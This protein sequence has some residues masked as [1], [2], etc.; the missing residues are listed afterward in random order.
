MRCQRCHGRPRGHLAAAAGPAGAG[1]ALAARH[2][3]LCQAPGAPPPGCIRLCA[4]LVRV[5]A[6]QLQLQ[7]PSGRLK[8]LP[9]C[10]ASCW[11]AAAAGELTACTILQEI[12]VG[13][14]SWQARLQSC[15]TLGSPVLLRDYAGAA[16]PALVELLQCKV[17]ALPPHPAWTLGVC[18]HARPAACPAA[19][20]CGSAAD[21]VLAK[22]A[23]V[24]SL[25]A[26]STGAH[27]RH[28]AWPHPRPSPWPGPLWRCTPASA[29]T[30]TAPAGRPRRWQCRPSR[31]CCGRPA[32]TAAS[33]SCWP[34]SCAPSGPT[35][36]ASTPS[37]WPGSPRTSAKSRCATRLCLLLLPGYL[38]ARRPAPG[39]RL[40]ACP[41]W[42]PVWQGHSRQLLP[43]GGC[44]LVGCSCALRAWQR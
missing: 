36:R 44:R 25:R 3:E 42:R 20:T 32:R 35:C 14:A 4:R 12:R 29:C 27:R 24:P 28:P 37:C 23:S 40:P 26:D 39:R 31:P 9:R 5:A 21:L 11:P 13:S 33:R 1:A 18:R 15:V 10:C 17:G 30:C 8:P 7:E 16:D 43:L 22:L 41:A 38:S 6:S 34:P 19:H 2:G